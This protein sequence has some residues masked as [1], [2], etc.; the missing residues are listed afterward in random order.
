[1]FRLPDIPTP[2]YK[3]MQEVREKLNLSQWQFFIL[4]IASVLELAQVNNAKLT[5]LAN[6]CRT[7]KPGNWKPPAE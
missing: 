6:D 7:Q 2:W 3:K 1:M 5:E 4:A